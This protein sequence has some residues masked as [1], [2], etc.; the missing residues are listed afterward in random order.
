MDYSL[1]LR[2]AGA[3]RQGANREAHA[4]WQGYDFDALFE[5]DC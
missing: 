4:Q 2:E 5:D 1:I 3:S